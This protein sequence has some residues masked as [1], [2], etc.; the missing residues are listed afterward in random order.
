MQS[1]IRRSKNQDVSRSKSSCLPDMPSMIIRTGLRPGYLTAMPPIEQIYLASV[2]K[3]ASFQKEM[4]L[5]Y[6]I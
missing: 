1:L 3:Y 5:D 4:K 2:L 6:I